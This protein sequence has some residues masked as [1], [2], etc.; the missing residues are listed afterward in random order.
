MVSVEPDAAP[1]PVRVLLVVV[2]VALVMGGLAGAFSIHNT[3]IGW[4]LA[5]GRWMLEHGQ[6]IRSDPFSFTAAGTEWVD[7]EWLFQVIVALAEKAGGG[8]GLVLLRCLVTAALAWMLLAVGL[9]GGLAPPVALVLAVG[10]VFAARMRF[11]MRPELCTIVLAPLAIWVFC[12]RSDS[13]TR[14]M[15]VLAL[16]V[17]L[18][19]NLHGAALMIPILI[20]AVWTGELVRSWRQG[21]PDRRRLLRGGGGV[22]LACVAPLVNPYGWKLYAVPLKITHLVGLAH[23]PNPEWIAPGP[24]EVPVLWVALA[25]ALLLL[26]IKERDPGRWL[27][28]L[29]IAALA[30]RW[31]RNVGLFFTVLPLAVAPAAARVRL[32]AG[33]GPLIRPG[34]ARRLAMWLASAA[35]VAMALGAVSGGFHPLGISFAPSVYPIRACDFLEDNGLVDEPRYNDVAFGGYLIGRFFPPL[36]VFLDDRNEIH[37][38]LLREIWTLFER[39][40]V[41]GWQAMLERH[42]VAVALVRYH[43]PFEVSRPDGTLIG[44]RGFSALWFRRADWALVYWDDVAMVFVRRN[45]AHRELIAELEY[46]LI[47][48]D[49]LAHLGQQ[50]AADQVNAGEVAAEV[51]RKLSEEPSCERAL[52]I[53]ER[54]LVPRR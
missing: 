7:H 25:A 3:S 54:I 31:V 32:L 23:V 29:A 28:F 13:S 39:S 45:E 34:P 48:P 50:I 8:P 2:L 5:S 24:A 1:V 46:R 26:A 30:L 10:C 42:Q 19:V 37:E 15:P 16:L 27:L 47:R 21:W 18:A 22:A 17:I 6:F 51:S 43:P 11:F 4:H 12:R 49:D 9:R 52:H 14:W 40:D 53:A 33:D 41:A 38:P 36:K 35:A 44:E 20:G